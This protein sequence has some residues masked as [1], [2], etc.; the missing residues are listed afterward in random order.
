MIPNVS[1]LCSY[2]KYFWWV[3]KDCSV[4]LIEWN[5]SLSVL[6]KV[7]C[8]CCRWG[9]SEELTGFAAPL[10]D[11]PTRPSPDFQKTLLV[12]INGWFPEP[13]AVGTSSPL[14]AGTRVP[15]AGFKQRRWRWPGAPVVTPAFRRKEAA[16][17]RALGA[18]ACLGSS[19][20]CT[21]G[22]EMLTA[23]RASLDHVSPGW[24]WCLE[25][26]VLTTPLDCEGAH[27]TPESRH[28]QPVLPVGAWGGLS[29]HHPGLT[30]TDPSLLC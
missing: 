7:V 21:R 20:L 24:G 15:C 29:G 1:I 14:P 22:V 26:W 8:P 3:E 25:P 23:P 19:C 18:K 9:F 5:T 12:Q 11:S 10:C 6:Y 16:P 30:C 28:R 4:S 27:G 13:A 17:R 2:R